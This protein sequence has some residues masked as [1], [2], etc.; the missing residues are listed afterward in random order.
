MPDPEGLLEDWLT[1]A[2]SREATGDYDDCKLDP[3][4]ALLRRL[5]APPAPVTIA[6]TKGKGSTLRLLEGILRAHERPTVAFTSPHVRTVR[7]RWRVDGRVVDAATAWAA[8]RTVDRAER[9]AGLVQSYFERCFA[10]ACVLAAGHPSAIFLLEV[11]LGGRLDCANA[12]DCRLALLAHVGY[13]HCELLGDSPGAIAREKCAVARPDRP[14]LVGPQVH[15]D[16]E[17]LSEA[18]PP[19]VQA[20]MVDR[21]LVPSDWDVGL[22]GTHQRDN[23]ALALAAA[24]LL[25]ERPDEARLRAGLAEARLAARCQL[26]VRPE[27]RLLIDAAHH[28]RS[29]AATLAH[30]ETVLRPGWICIC[31]LAR[32]KDM[33]RI[34][35]VLTGSRLWRCGYDWPRARCLADW[36][37]HLQQTPWFDRIDTALAALPADV[38]ACIC[39]SFYLAGE[40]LARLAP[41]DPLPG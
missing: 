5:P 12:L 4:R 37:P 30:A 9:A 16:A 38:D 13:D 25:I 39:G 33:Q 24:R 26:L 27:R 23:A 2:V 8:A 18:L 31:G 35:P 22:P 17:Q 34:A 28:D 15:L 19:G 36:P 1:Q 21:E 40:A 20:R 32:D 41:D 6:G 11:G 14:L 29:L 7:E 10:I 3:V